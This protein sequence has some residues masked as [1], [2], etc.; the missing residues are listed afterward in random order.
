MR[1]NDIDTPALDATSIFCPELSLPIRR[2]INKQVSV[3]Q[4]CVVATREKRSENRVKHICQVNDWVLKKSEE[5]QG[6]FYYLIHK[7]T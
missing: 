7:A 5:V 4:D 1:S 6:V 3:G 2:F